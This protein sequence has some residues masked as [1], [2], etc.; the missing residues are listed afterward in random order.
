MTRFAAAIVLLA[1]SLSTTLHAQESADP[2]A[3]V[4]DVPGLPRVLLIGDSIS[5]GYTLGVREG[6]AGKA[7]VHRPAVN[8]ADTQYGINH[9]EEWLGDKRWDVIH[10]NWGLHDLKYINENY[11]L[12]PVEKAVMQLCSPAQY[13]VNLDVLVEKLK[14]TGA[15]LIFATTTPVPEGAVGR[16][17][18]DEVRYNEVANEVMADH[19]VEVNDLHA[20]VAP[21]LAEYQRPA[22]VHFEDAGN[23]ALA[24]KVADAIES[25]FNA[26]T[27]RSRRS[28]EKRGGTTDAHR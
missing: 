1:L 5:I 17:P 23:E 25:G 27:Q 13:G 3:A 6:L 10:F 7:N 26:E 19:G 8:C 12:T 20:F 14:A 16:V 28:A 9:L 11:L 15:A 2:L 4:N 21:R 22:N 18:G 24:E